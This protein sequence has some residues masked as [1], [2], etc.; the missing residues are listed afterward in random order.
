MSDPL[1]RPEVLALHHEL[2]AFDCGHEALNTYLKRFAWTNQR[3]GAATT[4]VACR[5][6][7]VV[8]YHSLAFGSLAYESTT[9]RVR[10]GLARHP[11]P[12]M[13]LA[14]LAVDRTEQHQ[15]IGEGLLKDALRRTVQAA[16]IAGLRAIVV[17]AKGARSRAFYEKFDFIRSPV[18]E[19]ELMLLLKDMRRVI[20]P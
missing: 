20:Q 10:K 14:R 7:R 15:G 9:D 5:A 12:V 8:G 6:M 13:V 2:D 16:E 11:I 19:F 3:A 1:R 4:Y 17:H 18:D